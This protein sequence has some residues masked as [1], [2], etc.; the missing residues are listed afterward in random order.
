MKIYRFLLLLSVLAVCVTACK[1]DEEES[2]TDVT[3]SCSLPDGISEATLSNVA[4]SATNVSTGQTAN[5]QLTELNQN[6]WTFNLVDGLYSF[7]F[8]SDMTYTI[9]GESVTDKAKGLKE[10]VTIVG[11]TIEVNMQLYLSK[12]GGDFIIAEIFFTGSLTPEGN[13]YTGD[14]YYRIFNNSDTVLFADGLTILES[15]FLT[16]SMEEYTPNIMSDAM[17]V[18]AVYRV[19]GSGT[20]YPVEP[21]KSILIC[22]NAQDHTQA[23]SNSFDLTAANFEWY[24]ESSNPNFVD[25]DNPEVANLDKIYCYTATIWGP[26]N[27][28][29]TSHAL[30]R[31][32][33]NLSIETYLSDYTYHYEY[34]FVFGDNSFPM[35]GDT[36][37]FP[38]NWIID[39]VNLSVE[40]VYEWLVVDPSL[41]MGWTYCG[42]VN[43][44]P[45][46]YGKS[47]RRKTLSTTPSGRVYLKDTNNSTLDFDAEQT[48]NPFFF[49]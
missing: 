25:V 30:G 49:E 10:S 29:F 1:D 20:D 41:D 38:N 8:E 12:I 18:Q 4:I 42:T 7:S 6:S 44:D 19:P 43:S 33:Q 47:V 16:T 40:A 24:D 22:D 27:R 3:F 2:R 36:Y 32:P 11:G 45:T 23:N 35:D 28:G 13:Q 34:T 5:V 21:G 26:H 9:D 31:W 37:Q 17:A 46:R 39:A 15:E 14:K 48:A